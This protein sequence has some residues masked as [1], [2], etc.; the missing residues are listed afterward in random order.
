MP[1]LTHMI[2]THAHDVA[3]SVM[4]LLMISDLHSMSRT[5]RS[6][7][8]VALAVMRRRFRSLLVR[9]LAFFVLTF[10]IFTFLDFNFFIF[11]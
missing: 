2:V 3:A 8:A 1:V 6:V 11:A 9:F 7:R 4:E 10:F 5:S